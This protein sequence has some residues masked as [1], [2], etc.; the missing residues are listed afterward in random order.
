MLNPQAS[1]RDKFTFELKWYIPLPDIVIFEEPGVEPRES[2]PANL[3][4]L[5][6]A[7]STVRDQLLWEEKGSSNNG[8][9]GE[10]QRRTSRSEK[11]RKK[12]ADLEAQLVLASPNLIFRVGNRT[13][14][15]YTFF[16]SSEFERTQ[17][18]EAVHALQVN[19]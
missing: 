6:S 19:T 5:K 9:G 11:H 4:A 14:R 8:G 12:L 17:W 18:I 2:S 15:V 13:S 1:G 16:L 3:V 10:R 7:A